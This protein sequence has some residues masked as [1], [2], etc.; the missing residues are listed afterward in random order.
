MTKAFF[1]PYWEGLGPTVVYGRWAGVNVAWAC[2]L[3]VYHCLVSIAVPIVLVGLVFT[4][5]RSESWAGRR[6][7][8]VLAVLLLADVLVIFLL[9]GGR[10]P[11]MPE[12]VP[13]PPYRPPVVPYLAAVA[14]VVL[15][16][17][18]A[19]RL[20]V[21]PR[22]A[23]LD[24]P[25]A[26]R[27]VWFYLLGLVATPL[28]FIVSFAIPNLVSD[29]RRPHAIIEILA[30]A[31][32]VVVGIRLVWRM[33]RGGCVWTDN[34]ALALVAGA[35]TVFIIAA[36]IREFAGDPSGKNMRGMLLVGIAWTVFLFALRR[37]IRRRAGRPTGLV[38]GSAGGAGS[39]D[40]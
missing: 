37:A 31:T 26:A 32:V 38:R 15:L 3:L 39:P 4:G 23:P 10:P 29:G 30:Q 16:V 24:T 22:A 13:T 7:Q 1:D 11:G 19:K 18:W 17:L 14:A 12:G 36:G 21:V 2:G 28:F 34:R 20:P 5:R 9:A 6:T 40:R 27:P 35:L 25:A 33:T 8:I